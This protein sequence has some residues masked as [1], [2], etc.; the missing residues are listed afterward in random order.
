MIKNDKKKNLFPLK[1]IKMSNENCP[2][3][4]FRK[5]KEEPYCDSPNMYEEKGGSGG[6]EGPAEFYLCFYSFMDKCTYRDSDKNDNWAWASNW[7]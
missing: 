6:F 3:R 2:H 5:G 4:Y 1:Q 7:K